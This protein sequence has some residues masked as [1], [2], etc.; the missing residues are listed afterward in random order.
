MLSVELGTNLTG[1]HIT[2]ELFPFNYNEFC[3]FNSLDHE[4]ESYL[5]YLEKGG[6]PEFLKTG[7]S[8]LLS[9]LLE[10]ILYRDKATRYAIRDVSGLKKLCIYIISNTAKAVSPSKLT[11]VIGVKSSSTVL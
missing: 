9:F 1:R 6:F 3:S 4:K 5:S 11:C 2:K 10:D 7:N 8:E